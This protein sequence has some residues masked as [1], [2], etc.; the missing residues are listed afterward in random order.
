[1]LVLNTQFESLTMLIEVYSLI[2]SWQTS[3]RDVEFAS[4]R[5]NL[6]YKYFLT[7]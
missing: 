3:Y 2:S 1:M 5:E 7:H 6:Y 4:G